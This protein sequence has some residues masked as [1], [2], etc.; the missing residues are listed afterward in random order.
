MA[1]CFRETRKSCLTANRG[2]LAAAEEILRAGLK[3]TR[4]ANYYLFLSLFS[5]RIG[6][7][8]GGCWR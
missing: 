7:R 4:E 6:C 2:D 3:R 8:V 5:E 1:R